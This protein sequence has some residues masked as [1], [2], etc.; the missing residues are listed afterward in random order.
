MMR[1]FVKWLVHDDQA[2]LYGIVFASVL[3]I[4]FLLLVA[5]LF[6]TV[7]SPGLAFRLAKGYLV[8]WVLTALTALLVNRGQRFFRVNI[9]NHPDAYVNSNLAVSCFLQAGWSAFAALIVYSFAVAAPVWLM[10]ILYLVGILSCFIAYNIV[11]SFYQGHIYKIISL[12][13]AFVGFI[14]FSIWPA[15]GRL[16]FGRFFELF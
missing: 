12:P 15:S 7:G 1:D 10:L 3:N 8:L 11:S 4:V 9:Y 16:T 6:W 14:I 2:E 5:L 13:L